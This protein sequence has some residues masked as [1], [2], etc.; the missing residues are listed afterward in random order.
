MSGL[1][2]D[3]L[4]LVV[5]ADRAENDGSYRRQSKLDNQK[6]GGRLGL[7]QS[8]ETAALFSLAGA[9]CVVLH[10]WAVDFR[11]L[12][13]FVAGFSA[14]LGSGKMVCE[15]LKEFKEKKLGGERGLKMRNKY[16]VLCVGL[17]QMSLQGGK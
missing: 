16:N 4:N 9:N 2:V 14:S 3:G 13:E 10:R 12:G 1:N 11:M 8:L 7:E 17:P 6:D 15:G 5:L